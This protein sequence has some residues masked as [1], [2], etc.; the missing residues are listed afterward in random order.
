LGTNNE[1]LITMDRNITIKKTLMINAKSLFP[2]IR[3]Y[4][5]SYITMGKGVSFNN[6][7]HLTATKKAEIIIGDNVLF[8]PFV[9]INTG[10]HGYKDSNRLIRDQECYR[11]SIKIGNDVWVGAHVSIL[12]GSNIPDKCVIGAGSVVNRKDNL[13]KGGVYAGSPIRLIK[14]GCHNVSCSFYNE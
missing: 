12:A 10:N 9:M 2:D 14:K 13:E 1:V 6:Y 11:R 8:G 5:D 7:C 4:G 3:V